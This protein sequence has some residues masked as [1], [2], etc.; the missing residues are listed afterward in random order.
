M[1]IG[2]IRLADDTTTVNSIG[3]RLE[4]FYDGMWGSVCDTY[5][6]FTTAE[7]VCRQLGKE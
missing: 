7:V 1:L 4:I 2:E 6:N 5:L 3:G